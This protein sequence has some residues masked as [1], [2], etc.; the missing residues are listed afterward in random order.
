[1]FLL[2]DKLE[3]PNQNQATSEGL[4]A[5]GGDLS[6]ERLLLAYQNGI[7]P[8]FNSDE[9]LILW[10]TPDPRFVLFPDR[11]K[12]S[13]SMAQVLRNKDFTVTVNN[14]FESVIAECS[15]AKRSGEAGTWITQEMIKAYTEL[16]QLGYAKS[17]E[18]WQNEKLV[19]GFYGIDLGNGVFCGESMFAKVSNASKV[20]F[21]SFIQHTHYRIIDCQVYTKHLDSLGAE[22]IRRDEFLSYLQK[23]SKF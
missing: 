11:L 12:V 2:T 19:G 4:L 20:A 10:W 14:D 9:D 8:W 23:N 6:A 21:I 13:K 1:M 18:V 3:F 16:H 22:E 5:V 7:F 17:V 15:R